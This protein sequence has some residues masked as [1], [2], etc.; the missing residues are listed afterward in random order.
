M[1]HHNVP[2]LPR[3]SDVPE[4]Q[5]SPIPLVCNANLRHP[6]CRDVRL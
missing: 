3:I 6:P 5:S 2:K 1:S 4:R